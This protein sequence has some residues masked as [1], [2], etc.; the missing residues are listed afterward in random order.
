MGVTEG[1]EQRAGA[2]ISFLLSEAA[3]SALRQSLLDRACVSYL[4]ECL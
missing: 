3:E 4:L 1:V 2:M